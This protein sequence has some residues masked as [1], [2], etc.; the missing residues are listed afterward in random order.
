ML[1]C[2]WLEILSKT[3]FNLLRFLLWLL[4]GR[5]SLIGLLFLLGEEVTAAEP[6][7][8]VS[9]MMMLELSDGA[10]PERDTVGRAPHLEG[11][12]AAPDLISLTARTNCV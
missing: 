6:G 8:A 9:A 12:L 3:A 5:S 10:Q 7:L 4:I 2:K 11:V 1:C